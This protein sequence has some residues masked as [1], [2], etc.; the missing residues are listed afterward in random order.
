M[1]KSSS[2]GDQMRWRLFPIFLGAA[3]LVVTVGALMVPNALQAAQFAGPAATK[4]I[5]SLT[6]DDGS[7]SQYSTL[8]MLRSRGMQGTY[9]VNS[10]MVGSSSYYMKWSQIHD[11]ANAG[12]EVT[13]HTLHDTNLTA[14]SPSTARREVC[15]DRANLLKRGFSPVASFAYPFAAVNATAKQIVTDCG[16][17]SGR[18]VGGVV[19]GSLCRAC[20]YAETIRPRDRFALRTPKGVV[21]TTTL[22]QLKSYVTQAESHGGG[23]VVL[24]FH[25]ICSNGCAGS[26]SLNPAVFKAFLD[27]LQPRTA[28]GTVVRTVGG[29]MGAATR[30]SPA[31]AST[32]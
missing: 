30:S 11:L 25:G 10:A 8:P 1:L 5:V 13:G 31:G 18:S 21:S 16:Y 26:N 24:T 29:V 32:R 27:W 2:V 15:D 17:A 14:V 3:A 20:P 23:W 12:N 28:A 22:A 19:S 4:T 9:Y 6:F 7:T